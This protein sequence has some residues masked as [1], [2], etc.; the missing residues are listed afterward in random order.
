MQSVLITG[1]DTSLAEDQ[2]NQEFRIPSCGGDRLVVHRNVA[3]CTYLADCSGPKVLEIEQSNS[4][5]LRYPVG[6]DAVPLIAW[7]DLMTDE[8]WV[9]LH[10]QTKKPFRSSGE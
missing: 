5:Q 3:E 2:H 8:Q 10:R 7:R 6:P 4:W 1:T 9:N